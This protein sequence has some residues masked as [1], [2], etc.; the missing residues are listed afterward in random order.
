MWWLVSAVAQAAPGGFWHPADLAPVSERYRTSAEELQAP[1]EERSAASERLAAALRHYRENLDLL[2]DRAPAGERARLEGL[3]REY[4][5]QHAELQAFADQLVAD[6][7]AAFMGA[8]ERAVAAHGGEVV[9]CEATVSQGRA[10][11]GVPTRRAANPD[12]AGENLNAALAAAV[13]G[14]AALAGQLE[15]ILGR[16]WPAVALESAAQ[17]PVGGAARWIEVRDLLMAGAR[18]A[19]Q[20]ID[21]RDDDARG[22]IEAAIEQGASVEALRELTPEAERIEAETAAARAALAAPVLAAV[23]AR[24]AKKWASEPPVGWCANPPALGGCTGEDATRALVSRLVADK[25]VA[26]VL[27]SAK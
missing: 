17:A 3:E 24:I 9:Q 11:P 21:Q 18:G 12:C 20:R 25:K 5:R 8:V 19:L 16:G 27:A 10:L 26:K 22:K 14:D 4:Q 1:F 2:G 7:D 23:E 13:D 6:Y 15:A